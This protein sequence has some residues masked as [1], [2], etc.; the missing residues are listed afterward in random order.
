MHRLVL[1][2][3]WVCTF[4]VP[5]FA[6]TQVAPAT[7]SPEDADSK[8]SKAGADGEAEKRRRETATFLLTALADDAS[9][10]ADLRLRARVQTRVADTLWA[11]DRERSLSLFRKAWDS[12]AAAHDEAV[13]KAAENAGK[14]T[15]PTVSFDADP[16]EEVL[17]AVARRDRKLAESLLAKLTESR[18]REA[19]DTQAARPTDAKRSLFS[20]PDDATAQRLRLAASLVEADQVAAALEIADPVLRTVSVEAVEFL[21]NLRTKDA[22]AADA[23]FAT[24]STQ[25]GVD[26]TSDAFTISILSAYLYSPHSYVL[27]NSYSVM[28]AARPPDVGPDIRAAFFRAVA[29]VLLRPLGPEQLDA[30]APGRQGTYLVCARLLPLVERDAPQLVEQFRTRMNTMGLDDADGITQANKSFL[31]TGLGSEAGQ[32]FGERAAS[33]LDEKIEA[34]SHAQKGDERDAAYFRAAVTAVGAGD[35]RAQELADA[36]DDP[37]VRKALRAYVDVALVQSAINDKKADDAVRLIHAGGATS[38][39]RAWL[40]CAAARLTAEKDRTRAREIME[41]ATDAARHVDLDDVERT[42]ALFGVATSWV[43][44]DQ[45]RVSNA[46]FEAV[47]SANR[48]PSFTGEDAGVA[49]VLQSKFG[50]FVSGFGAA[51]LTIDK[52]L[53]FLAR[54]D[55]TGAIGVAKSFVAESPRSKA[56]LVVGETVLGGS[57][58]PTGK[59]TEKQ[60]HEEQQRQSN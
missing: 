55:L 24:M 5:A 2:L 10:F 49:I 47:A 45:Q 31:S 58:P 37:D 41:E 7:K 57:K 15:G 14:R 51:E 35:P 18:E 56:I 16:R 1:A 59:T 54:T 19:D 42:R 48:T 46:V 33:S 60:A 22:A 17:R 6:R 28:G 44:V 34:A 32:S 36:V 8:V 23:R 40:L 29:Q 3:V 27:P 25:T 9:S 4:G 53:A 52:P 39:Q 38:F 12:A 20:G 21:T 50:N 43:D 26:P 30:T 13:R 11:S